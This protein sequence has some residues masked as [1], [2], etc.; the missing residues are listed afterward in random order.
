M[1]PNNKPKKLVSNINGG[2]VSLSF[3]VHA[4]SLFLF[5]ILACRVVFTFGKPDLT[6]DSAIAEVHVERHHRI[7]R[8]FDFADEFAD[9]CFVQQ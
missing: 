2:V 5:L 6:F 7:A 8:T 1:P 3:A 9:L 4:A